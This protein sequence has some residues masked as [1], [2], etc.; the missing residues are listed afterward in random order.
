MGINASDGVAIDLDDVQKNFVYNTDGTL[1][2]TEVFTM[3]A[4]YR[5]TCGYTN[6]QL[7]SISRWEKQ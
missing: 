7:T 4:T 3:G 2:Y 1:N 5:E 6:G